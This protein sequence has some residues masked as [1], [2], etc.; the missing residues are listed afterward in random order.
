M[1]TACFDLAYGIPARLEELGVLNSAAREA[2]DKNSDLYNVLCRSCCV[3]LAA[4]LE[5][6]LKDLSF[7]LTTDLNSHLKKFKLYPEALQ[8]T[9]CNKIAFYEGVAQNEIYTRTKQLKA[10]FSEK[11]VKIDLKAFPYKE[12]QNKN[13]SSNFIEQSM[14]SIGIPSVL[15]L[16]DTSN[17]KVVFN[18]SERQ[19][20]IIYR[21]MR[22]RASLLYKFPYKVMRGGYLAKKPKNKI[23]TMWHT[24]VEDIMTRRHNIVHGDIKSNDAS[25]DGLA[26][27][28]AKLGMLMYGITYASTSYLSK[29]I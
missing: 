25:W 8:N 29:Q 9:F 15:H 7:S 28:T 14:E 2:Q 17:M 27:D 5:G 1:S 19:N 23:E 6:F 18:E 11:D 4:H 24:F 20:Y 22:K 21:E 12:S 3:L 13:P 16:I 26:H 10:Y